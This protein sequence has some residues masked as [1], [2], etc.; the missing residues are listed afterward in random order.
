MVLRS[1]FLV[2][3]CGV[4]SS[5]P[6]SLRGGA[7]LTTLSFSGFW[8]QRNLSGLGCQQ[9]QCLSTVGE[10]LYKSFFFRTYY[11]VSS[12]HR[13]VVPGWASDS[14]RAWEKGEDP[15]LPPQNI[16]VLRHV[17]PTILMRKWQ[18]APL[19]RKQVA[20]EQCS[21]SALKARVSVTHSPGTRSKRYVGHPLRR[22]SNK[23]A[24]I[25]YQN[26]PT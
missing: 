24:W 22:A 17:T 16:I 26:P 14:A 6:Q 4:W 2:V 8:P 15:S 5:I 13:K 23:E 10:K 3:V 9:S 7:R 21:Q 20:H 25:S 11:D 1:G 18:F 12:A 19:G